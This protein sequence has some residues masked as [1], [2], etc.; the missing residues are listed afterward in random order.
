[1]I[2]KEKKEKHWFTA[3]DALIIIIVAALIIGSAV[4]FLFSDK[5]EPAVKLIKATVVVHLDDEISGIQANDKLFVSETEIGS[6]QKIDKAAN[7]VVAIIEVEKEDGVYYLQGNPVRVN[8]SFTLETRLF[9]AV[10][11]VTDVGDKEA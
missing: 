11:V 4:L 9:K 5:E 1:M 6:V 2:I 3:A 8:G 7:N 10:G